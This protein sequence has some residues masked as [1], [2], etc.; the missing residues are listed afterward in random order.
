MRSH[1]SVHTAVR[2]AEVIGLIWFVVAMLAMGTALAGAYVVVLPF[3]AAVAS[4]LCA[5]SLT[6]GLAIEYHAR[7]P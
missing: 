1:M 3:I 5:V 2:V 4:G 6:A 7:R